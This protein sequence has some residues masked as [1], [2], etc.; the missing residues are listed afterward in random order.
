M[1]KTDV[2]AM[3]EFVVNDGVLAEMQEETPIVVEEKV[4]GKTAKTPKIASSSSFEFDG[5]DFN[6]SNWDIKREGE[7]IVAVNQVTGNV[8]TGDPKD[9]SSLLKG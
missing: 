2:P 9:F 5:E 8:F 6:P 7:A 3:N 4:V 1:A